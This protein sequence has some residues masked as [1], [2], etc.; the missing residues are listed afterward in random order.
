M[1]SKTIYLAALL[2]AVPWAC[3]KTPITSPEGSPS[4]VRLS[5]GLE[6][7]AITKATEEGTE[8]ENSVSSMTVSVFKDA[9]GDAMFEA[10]GRSYNSSLNITVTNGPK[11]LFALVNHPENTEAET[12]LGSI[13]EKESFLKDNARSRFVMSGSRSATVSEGNSTVT[14][15]VDRI[16]ARIKIGKITNRLDNGFASRDVSLRRIFLTHVAA[17][18]NI[19]MDAEADE[20]YA[21]TGIGTLLDLEGESIGQEEKS[22]VNSLIFSQIGSPVI[23]ENASC[24]SVPALYAYPNSGARAKTRVVAEMSIDG[25]FFTYPVEFSALLPNHSYQIEELVLRSLG[26]P[27]NGDD[28]I[29]PGEDEPVTRSEA[30]FSVSVKDWEI[31]PVS[32]GEDGKYTI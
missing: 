18:S 30:V 13:L 31:V 14:I 8:A 27:S 17:S 9:G 19:G 15:P 5:V 16:A 6:S 3:T 10:S 28:V 25:K 24:A 26:N 12:S 20:F 29:D 32:N 11:I 2:A 7:T 22:A 4:M 21:N 23:A 1:K